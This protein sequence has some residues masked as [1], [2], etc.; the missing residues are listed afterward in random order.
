[1][2]TWSEGTLLPTELEDEIIDYLWNDRNSL[3]ACSLANKFMVVPCQRR[4]FHCIFYHSDGTSAKFLKLI[5]ESPHI[6]G[7]VVSLFIHDHINPCLRDDERIDPLDA[8]MV[9]YTESEEKYCRLGGG[10]R[11]PQDKYLPD[12]APLLCN[13]RALTI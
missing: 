4:L 3:K 13:L 12:V 8:P 1:M 9:A 5:T 10:H 7:Y 6:A 2:F 11:L